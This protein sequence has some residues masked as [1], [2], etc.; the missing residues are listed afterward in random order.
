MLLDSAPKYVDEI[1]IHYKSELVNDALAGRLLE[2][3]GG[4]AVNG[5]LAIQV[6]V[7]VRL[8][9]GKASLRLACQRC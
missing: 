7:A 9:Y 5:L 6:P 1:E 8:F 4:V 3:T 2:V